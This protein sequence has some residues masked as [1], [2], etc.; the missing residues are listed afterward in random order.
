M[1]IIDYQSQVM[2]YSLLLR[3]ISDRLTVYIQEFLFAH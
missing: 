2:H 1:M 3:N